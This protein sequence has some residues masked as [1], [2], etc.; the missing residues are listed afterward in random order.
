[1]KEQEIIQ[2]ENRLFEAVSGIDTPDSTPFFLLKKEDITE[3]YK[4]ALYAYVGV[5]HANDDDE[6]QARIA[7]DKASYALAQ[8]LWA[9]MDD[10]RQK[11]QEIKR[12]YKGTRFYGALRR[13]G[14][15]EAIARG[16]V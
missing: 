9:E 7:Y 15:S 6:E 13:A 4:N 11:A 2:I 16:I 5:T 1:M 12:A 3:A 8:K 10:L 14:L